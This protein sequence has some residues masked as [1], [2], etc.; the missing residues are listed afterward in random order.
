MIKVLIPT[1]FSENSLKSI[2]YA[3]SIWGLIDVQYHFLHT[4]EILITRGSD[5]LSTL[6]IEKE[7]EADKNLTHL[8][9]ILIQKYPPIQFSLEYQYGV[10]SDFINTIPKKKYDFIVMGTKG[11]S[12]IKEVFLGSNT[13]DVISNTLLPVL[14]IPSYVKL[15]QPKNILIALDPTKKIS[16][17]LIQNL[18]LLKKYISFKINLLLIQKNEAIDYVEI[19]EKFSEIDYSLN[20][21]ES[22]DVLNSII[23]Y[24][25]ENNIDLL[26]LINQKRSFWDSIFHNS[27][28]K[29]LTFH[30]S[31]PLLALKD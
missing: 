28:T 5:S 21:I 11:S 12:G 15:V 10:I 26:I 31:I 19:K 23:T 1:D 14:V 3:I 4:F 17:F 13:W 24:I 22:G 20:I 7:L 27:I 30:S 8:S 2:E 16:N 9:D 29:N 25:E 6:K 18:L